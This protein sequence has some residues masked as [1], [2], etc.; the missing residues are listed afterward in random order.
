MVMATSDA[1]RLDGIVARHSGNGPQNINSGRGEQFDNTISGGSG[2]TQ[3][4]NQSFHTPSGPSGE[5]LDLG[6]RKRSFVTDPKIDRAN[7]IDTKGAS[8]PT[9]CDWIQN[10][11]EYVSW[12]DGYATRPLWI[13]GEPGK[14]KTILSIFFVARA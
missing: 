2:N 9:T 3:Y 1:A 14:G 5:E 4:N 10:T 6:F 11:N 8:V 7:L 12:H 13:W